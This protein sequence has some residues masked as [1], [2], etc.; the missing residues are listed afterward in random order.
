MP[1]FLTPEG[2]QKIKQEIIELKEEK[3]LISER[4]RDAKELGDLSENSEY[5]TSKE[6]LARTNSRIKELE[7]LLKTAEV[8]DSRE[9]NDCIG[10]GS[11]IVI[12]MNGTEKEYKLVGSE[13]SDPSQGL[14]S[15]QSPFGEAL[16]DK[17]TGEKVEIQ[18]PKG[19]IK[20]IIKQIQ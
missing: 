13:E 7:N 9:K 8:V 15:Y 20:A 2:I 14:I 3:P 18:T 17:K 5:T 19:T 6:D 10:I 11:T 4:I 12:E 1:K 16:L